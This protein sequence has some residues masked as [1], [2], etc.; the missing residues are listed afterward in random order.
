LSQ[1][2][3]HPQTLLINF[4][5]QSSIL[6]TLQG[7]PVQLTNCGSALW[8]ADFMRRT[9]EWPPDALTRTLA[10]LLFGDESKPVLE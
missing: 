2:P 4:P 5:L 6:K 8:Q 9:G 10:M 3:R 1:T 7:S